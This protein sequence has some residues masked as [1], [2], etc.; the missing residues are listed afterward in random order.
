MR[1][2]ASGRQHISGVV[3]LVAH[4]PLEPRIL[5]RVQAPEPTFLSFL[6]LSAGRL[7]PQRKLLD[8]V[9]LGLIKAESV[10]KNTQAAE[11]CFWFLTISSNFAVT[12]FSRSFCSFRRSSEVRRSNPSN[13]ASGIAKFTIFPSRLIPAFRPDTIT[14]DASE[15]AANLALGHN[16]VKYILAFF[17]SDHAMTRS[18]APAITSC[19]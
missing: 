4:R 6:K 15:S 8:A 12:C 14:R 11:E 13:S 3:Q 7:S 16:P 17:S 10:R 2:C 1:W 9:G 18:S 5:V 19:K